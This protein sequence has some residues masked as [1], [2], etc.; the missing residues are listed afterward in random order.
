MSS[1]QSIDTVL[2]DGDPSIVYSDGWSGTPNSLITSYYNNTYHSTNNTRASATITFQGNAITVYGA[3]SGNHGA[4]TVTLDG[5]VS[6]GLNGSASA[7]RPQN[8][9]YYAGGLSND[10]HTLTI[11]N[12]DSSSKYFDLDKVMVSKWVNNNISAGTNSTGE[13]SAVGR[14]T[15]NLVGPIVGG[16]IGGVAFL[17]LILLALFFLRRRDHQRTNSNQHG[18]HPSAQYRRHHTSASREPMMIEPFHVSRY[19]AVPHVEPG[20]TFATGS[21]SG[22]SQWPPVV[23]QFGEATQGSSSVINRPNVRSAPV[24]SGL[25]KQTS[26]TTLSSSTLPYSNPASATTNTS[27]HRPTHSVFGSIAEELPPPNYA[28]ATASSPDINSMGR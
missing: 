24:S 26:S 27:V 8:M 23:S 4:F 13:P 1:S 21:G 7:F 19:G 18:D 17:V 5:G 6:V 14:K 3:T 20:S 10:S 25:S 16:V 9:L 11:V 28:E 15:K 2:D 22:A 12:I